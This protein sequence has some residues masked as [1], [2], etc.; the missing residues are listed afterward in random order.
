MNARRYPGLQLV[1]VFVT[2]NLWE[3]LAWMGFVQARLQ[4]R[5]NPSGAEAA[6]PA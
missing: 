5:R 6:G 3:E 2:F 4:Q 1:V